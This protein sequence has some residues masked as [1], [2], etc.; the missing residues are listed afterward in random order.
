MKVKADFCVE[1]VTC[2]DVQWCKDNGVETL[3]LDIDGTLRAEHAKK[4]SGEV[5]TWICSLKDAGIN[6]CLVSNANEGKVKKIAMELELPYIAEAEKPSSLGLKAAMQ[7]WGYKP[8]TTVM[9]GD[10][11]VDIIAGHCAG[12]RTVRVDR[13]E[14]EPKPKKKKKKKK[15]K[16]E[17]DEDDIQIYAV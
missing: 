17:K 3:L 6:L 1:C 13:I 14:D 11:R 15:A 7:A 9:V 2:L 12:V 4:F 16:K 10:R 8:K 5:L